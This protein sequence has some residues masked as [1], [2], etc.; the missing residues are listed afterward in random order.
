M[1]RRIFLI[2]VL[3]LVAIVLVLLQSTEWLVSLGGKVEGA[4]LARAERSPQWADGAFRNR[5]PRGTN[6]TS[7]R[8]MLRRQF[9]GDEQRE[10]VAPVPVVQRTARDY[11]TPP[12]SGLR[13]TWMGW[14]SV[15]VEIDGLK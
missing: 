1:K 13:A 2:I 8:E 14:S 7:N 6:R 5:E 12:A 15:L 10:P 3:L 11:A 9:F 4:R